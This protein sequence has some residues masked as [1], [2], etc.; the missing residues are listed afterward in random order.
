METITLRPIPNYKRYKITEYGRVFRT[1]HQGRG[2]WL[3]RREQK[4]DVRDTDYLRVN[5]MKDG[6]GL[7]KLVNVHRLVAMAFHWD[8]YE[9]GLTVIT[10]KGEFIK[11]WESQAVAADTLGIHRTGISACVTGNTKSSG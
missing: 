5:V 2:C 8:T 3:K 1:A 7:C 4:S 10:L 11:T 6:D 9:K